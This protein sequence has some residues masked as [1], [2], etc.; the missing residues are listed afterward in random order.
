MQNTGRMSDDSSREETARVLSESLGF[1]FVKWTLPCACC[2]E[3]MFNL[4][5]FFLYSPRSGSPIYVIFILWTVGE[6]GSK[7][8]FW[9]INRL[10]DDSAHA[11][12]TQPGADCFVLRRLSAG[13]WAKTPKEKSNSSFL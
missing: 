3:D 10:D 2:Q 1:V 11:T 9:T 7:S 6:E 12:S 5:L 4:V 8:G 13:T